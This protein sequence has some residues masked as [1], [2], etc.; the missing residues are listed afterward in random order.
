[1]QEQNNCYLNVS[2]LLLSTRAEK[3]QHKSA[4]HGLCVGMWR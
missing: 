1:V 2:A 4:F 3:L